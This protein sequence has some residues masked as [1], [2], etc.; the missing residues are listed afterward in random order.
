[1][2]DGAEAPSSGDDDLQRRPGNRPEP[3]RPAVAG[4]GLRRLVVLGPAL[5]R[6]G[7]RRRSKPSPAPPGGRDVTLDVCGSTFPGYEWFESSC[8]VVPG[9]RPGRCGRLLRLH[10]SDLAGARACRGVGR[11]V[12]AGA[13][14]QRR[15]RAQLAQRPVVAAAA[16][17]HL[18]TV[19]DGETGLLVTPGDAQGHRGRIARLLDD[20]ELAAR[21]AETARRTAEGDSRSPATGGGRRPARRGHGT[22]GGRQRRTV[23]LALTGAGE[24]VDQLACVADVRPRRRP[25]HHRVDVGLLVIHSSAS[26]GDGARGGAPTWPPPGSVGSEGRPCRRPCRPTSGTRSC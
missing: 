14:R 1:M 17:G 10:L 25:E 7:D 22:A 3:P 20:G 26:R 18:E 2:R 15:G 19:I 24:L 13:V 12:A 6:K 5:P 4:P 8:V 23:R 21:I 9:V 16:M 11:S